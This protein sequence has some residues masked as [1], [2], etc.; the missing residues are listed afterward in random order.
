MAPI[1]AASFCWTILVVNIV[2][3]WYYSVRL[4]LFECYVHLER[5]M[6]RCCWLGR[7]AFLWIQMVPVD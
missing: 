3:S 5:A 2:D 1:R 4:G 7:S 6:L